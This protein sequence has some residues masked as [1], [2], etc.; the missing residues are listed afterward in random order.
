MIRC[1]YARTQAPGFIMSSD[2]YLLA[3]AFSPQS[4]AVARPVAEEQSRA[5][6]VSVREL[7][8]VVALVVL[9][10]VT[11]FRGHGYGGLALLGLLSPAALLFGRSRATYS[12]TTFLIVLMIGLLAA[13]TAWLGS[14]LGVA[15]GAALL[16]AL[17]LALEGQR[18]YVLNVIAG[19]FQ[20]IPGAI[21]GWTDY[22]WAAKGVSPQ[23]PKIA[24][25]GILL[26]VGAVV[27][28]GSL[29]ILANPDLVT[30]VQN[31]VDQ[32]QRMLERW[33]GQADFPVL[34]IFF[35]F[36]A[37][38]AAIALLR[39]R[40]PAQRPPATTI[41]TTP[42]KG[43]EVSHAAPLFGACQNTL[44]AVS[45]LFAA[46]LAFEFGTLWFREFPKGFYY[47]GYAHKGAAWL[48]AALALATVVLSAIFQG[49]LL[50][51]PRLPRLKRL[52]WIWSAE[53]L[54][55]ALSVYNRMHIYVD[56]NGM[57]RMRVIGLFGITAVLVGFILVI[58]KIVHR[59]SFGWL[60]QHQL[61]TVAIATY[62][63]AL[64]PVDYLVHRYNVQ[65]ILAGDLAP[66]V[67]MT[68]H[69]VNTEGFLV[70]ES[71]IDCE[72]PIIREG[73]RAM[74]VERGIKREYGG[75]GSYSTS[76][77]NPAEQSWTSFQ[78][79]ERC[80]TDRLRERQA[81]LEPYQR[82]AELRAEAIREFRKYAYQWY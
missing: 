34:E 80:L 27:V 72:D 7:A 13:R 65:Q 58:W 47:A 10:D 59:R 66:S 64:T 50:N 36:F 61:W 17:V 43:G 55:L 81:E 71:L 42:S 82:D 1:W 32:L 2:P 14:V 40:M 25:L 31:G 51:D 70:L 68:E 60:V 52:A 24:W 28:F 77:P 11:I 33:L 62:L 78:L 20:L 69:P 44:L 53:N 57:T 54:L 79:A 18:P 56:F 75:P 15:W 35:C 8:A 67:Q 22:F 4:G 16:V 12:R 26:P 76:T 29:F 3:Q 9:A 48:T 73:V 30:A 46:Y 45:V 38:S 41:E 21:I 19:G 23:A 6:S 5:A 37:A 49:E 63:F 74:L 39:T